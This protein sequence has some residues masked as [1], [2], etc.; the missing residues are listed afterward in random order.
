M[1]PEEGLTDEQ[2]A[3]LEAKDA[4]EE[5]LTDEQ[6][7][8]LETGS[9]L[10]EAPPK[11][12]FVESV[13]DRIVAQIKEE[14]MRRYQEL[15]GF[16]KGFTGSDPIKAV[17]DITDDV[18]GI[19]QNIE[20][21]VQGVKSKGDAKGLH[22][23]EQDETGKQTQ[24]VGSA[25]ATAA[26][27]YSVA[28]AARAGLSKIDVQKGF[29]KVAEESKKALGNVYDEFATRYDNV[30]APVANNMADTASVQAQILASA[31][32]VPAGGVAEKYMGKLIDR[33]DNETVGGLHSLKQEIF[34]HSK[35]YIGPEKQA[36]KEVYNKINEVMALPQN[37]GPQYGQLTA[38]YNNFVNQEANYV[39]KRILDTFGNA[40]EKKLA[41]GKFDLNEKAAFE[42][43]NKRPTTGV[44]LLKEMK[45]L[46]QIKKVQ[47]GAKALG[48]KAVK[49]GL[50]A[51]AAALGYKAASKLGS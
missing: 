40:T 38:E 36:L 35:N 12:G 20:A 47:A 37:A 16:V 32:K 49:Y 7:A 25:I 21:T 44:D 45:R 6:M 41:S 28:N 26:I 39:K 27:A 33:L 10:V 51:G 42:A 11:K 48:G 18:A 14:P 5:G 34:K 2:L 19:K 30:V 31:D 3:H 29:K 50:T 15:T 43:L 8:K 24:N 9:R 46:E 17:N 4:P 22:I 23:P 1:V 13:R